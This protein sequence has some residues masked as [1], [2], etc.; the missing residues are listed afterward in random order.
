MVVNNIKTKALVI[1]I[2]RRL[3]SSFR[4]LLD[5]TVVERVTELKVHCVL[6]VTKLLFVIHIR[7]RAASLSSKLESKRN[8]QN[9]FSDPVLVSRCFWIFQC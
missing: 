5:G 7:L 9:L 1:L 8:T 3:V 2:S 4:N 6:L